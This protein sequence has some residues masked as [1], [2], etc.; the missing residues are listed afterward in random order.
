MV[1]RQFARI[2]LREDIDAATCVL[3]GENCAVVR[4]IPCEW[5]VVPNHEGCGL[6]GLCHLTAPG[7]TAVAPLCRLLS[8]EG[9]G[10]S[11]ERQLYFSSDRFSRSDRKVNI[12]STRG[13]CQAVDN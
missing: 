10:S 7:N 5:R 3:D 13:L 2:H 12:L 11:A 8:Y 9:N 6:T 1:G 4:E